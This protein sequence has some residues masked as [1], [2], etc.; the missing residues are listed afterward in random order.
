MQY[1]NTSNC[2]YKFDAWCVDE[3]LL[4]PVIPEDSFRFDIRLYPR[5]KVINKVEPVSKK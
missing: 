2:R 5:Y 3:A 1:F 4:Y